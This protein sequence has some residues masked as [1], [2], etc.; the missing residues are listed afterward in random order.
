MTLH[1]STGGSK[2]YNWPTLV[3][4][5]TGYALTLLGIVF[6]VRA[7]PL[8][9]WHPSMPGLLSMAGG[10]GVVLCTLWTISLANGFRAQMAVGLSISMGMLA[11]LLFLRGITMAYQVPHFG[12]I[13][14]VFTACAALTLLWVAIG[15]NADG[16]R[17]LQHER[18]LHETDPLTGT[19]N[20]RGLTRRYLELRL[21]ERVSVA[22]IDVNDLKAVND[23][24]GHS[25]G[26]TYLQHIA[27]T[28][29]QHL[30][31][32]A[33][34]SR[35]GGDEFVV[36]VP[37]DVDLQAL[38]A[39][40]ALTVPRPD[41][42]LPAYAVGTV[43]M[44][45]SEPLERALV[46]ADEGMYGQKA[47]HYAARS[48]QRDDPYVGLASFPHFLQSLATLDAILDL[49]L[50]K[51]ADLA[52]FRTWLY[53][54]VAD[55]LVV[56][57]HERSDRH[58]AQ[59]RRTLTLPSNRV[60]EAVVREQATVWSS[61]YEHSRY[62]EPSLADLKIKSFVAAPVKV[63]GV[64][65]A[66][67]AFT[68]SD[69]WRTISPEVR[70]VLDGVAAHLGHHME[71]QN[72][73]RKLQASVEAG[74]TGM[75]VLLEMRDMET[76]GHTRRVVDLAL[77]LGRAAGLD[78]DALNALRMGAYLHDIG[79]LAI[80]DAVLLKPGPLDAA[81]WALMQ[82]HARV[83]ADMAARVPSLPQAAL[84]VVLSHH[85][86]WDGGGYPHG[87]SGEGIPLLARIFGLCDVY[88]ALTHARP[89]KEAWSVDRAW[90]ELETQ[91]GR[92]F[93]PHLTALFLRLVA[94]PE[95]LKVG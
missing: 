71:R 2:P 74:I 22:M 20:R 75:G 55:P 64:V 39:P 56:T 14:L 51:A 61:D 62:A 38:L 95:R 18:H 65:T 47:G 41:P 46:L 63:D 31:A 78:D 85:E 44:L 88:D 69:R 37:G 73:Y 93:D 66:V 57:Y 94:A 30:P 6:L 45:A 87:L 11:D 36:L 3:V 49:G 67:V 48:A 52:D 68:S 86:R 42:A 10:A 58:P 77:A 5:F 72:V 89:Y 29:R 50:R 40:A 53:I 81:E 19:L 1:A 91:A 7:D 92:Q 59:G 25:E 79:K 16:L 13:E 54:P 27:A 12:Q 34:L 15:G 82:T 60:V 23:R 17:R 35:W 24:G 84:D 90:R 32:G 76:A 43:S 33:Q 70:Q 8:A 4:T 80:P 28:L 21:T 9:H 83:G 26:D